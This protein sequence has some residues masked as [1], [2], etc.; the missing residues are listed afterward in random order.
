LLALED[1]TLLAYFF[2]NN[3]P[4]TADLRRVVGKIRTT[5]VN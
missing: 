4:E 2:L 3:E 1:S 5:F